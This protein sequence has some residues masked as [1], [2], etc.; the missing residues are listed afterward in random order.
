MHC[1]LRLGI[2][3]RYKSYDS[4]IFFLFSLFICYLDEIKQ[5]IKPK[6][7]ANDKLVIKNAKRHQRLV[8]ANVHHGRNS[9]LPWRVCRY[10]KSS[11]SSTAVKSNSM[12][13]L[14]DSDTDDE[15]IELNEQ[16]ELNAKT[17]MNT[18]QLTQAN[19]SNV[20]D[21]DIIN[22]DSDDDQ[23]NE[24]IKY[25]IVESKDSSI[26]MIKLPEYC[27]A[28]YEI[29]DSNEVFGAK[30]RVIAQRNGEL[31]PYTKDPNN[32][33][34]LY[35][36]DNTAFFAGIIG[37]SKYKKNNVWHY[38]IF[39]DDGFVQYVDHSRIRLVFTNT[40]YKYS[41]QNLN[42]FCEYY[43]T[44]PSLDK[45]PEMICNVGCVVQVYVNGAFNKAYI[46]NEFI[47]DNHEL[48]T[49]FQIYFNK[50]KRFEW[51]YSGSPRFE[52]IWKHLNRSK[53]LDQFN[54]DMDKSTIELSSDSEDDELVTPSPKKSIGSHS[55]ELQE[56]YQVVRDSEAKDIIAGYKTTK[57]LKK[58]VCSNQCVIKFESNSAV[59][60]YAPLDRP[61][62]S[63][64][65]RLMKHSEN[66]RQIE[67]IT[68][69][70]RRYL[71]MV[72]VRK[73]L[74]ATNSR[75]TMD[76]FS[77][78]RKLRCLHEKITQAPPRSGGVCTLNE[79]SI[80]SFI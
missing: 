63:G 51:I 79:V 66:R 37:D 52:L 62:L 13:V 30:W 14:I 20:A 76:C 5:E 55:I 60:Q 34:F 72:R 12:T 73:Y 50:W 68:P 1:K 22:L 80:F 28:K 41:H 33:Y 4:K 6:P 64:W 39:F 56:S 35:K 45:T 18:T 54:P 3:V 10:K 75:L 17:D 67:Y 2:V 19:T 15:Y 58:H 38:L 9:L 7:T 47:P 40:S 44:G 70:G 78:D 61:I 57:H 21:D 77:L 27:I 53:M 65:Q 43:F 46:V 29:S 26:G 32:T 11:I 74:I 71:S 59:F 42:K 23:E 16:T 24:P 49:L 48:P 25:H 8:Y 36:N 69:C 31:F